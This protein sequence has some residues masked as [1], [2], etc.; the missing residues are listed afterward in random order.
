MRSNDLRN[1]HTIAYDLDTVEATYQLTLIFSSN[2]VIL[3]P[4]ARFRIITVRYKKH[5]YEANC[6]CEPLISARIPWSPTS[7]TLV[8]RNTLPFEY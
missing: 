5:K 4:P 7:F 8:T 6:L 1:V 3:V 2:L